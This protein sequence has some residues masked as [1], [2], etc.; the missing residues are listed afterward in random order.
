[1]ASLRPSSLRRTSLR[2]AVWLDEIHTETRTN[3]P[4]VSRLGPRARPAPAAATGVRLALPL[5][6]RARSSRI[7]T[8]FTHFIYKIVAIPVANSL[9]PFLLLAPPWTVL[10][11]HCSHPH[12]RCGSPR[13]SS[14]NTLNPN[15]INGHRMNGHAQSLGAYIRELCVTCFRT[16]RSC[17]FLPYPRCT[18]QCDCLLQ[19]A[20]RSSPALPSQYA[21]GPGVVLDLSSLL[22]LAQRSSFEKVGL[23][24]SRMED[25][26]CGPTACRS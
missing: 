17:L 11:R 15:Q 5:D 26:T 9:R 10:G 22:C 23:G 6:V 16:P 3:C 14:L 21:P 18:L 13:T 8:D 2:G 24:A 19:H 1:M 7:E 25:A 20:I 12:I 4:G